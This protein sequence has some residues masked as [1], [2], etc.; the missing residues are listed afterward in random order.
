MGHEGPGHAEHAGIADQRTAAQL[1][2]LAVVARRQVGA[3]FAD[4]LFDEMVVV[5]QPF[6]GGRDRRGPRR[7][8]WRCCG[9]LRAA[10]AS[11]SARRSTSDLPEAG[12][13]EMGWLAAR[14]SACCSSRSTLKSSLRMGSSSSHRETGCARP[15][16]RR[17][18]D[19]NGS[20]LSGNARQQGLPR[21]REASRERIA[22]DRCPSTAND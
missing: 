11:L 10:R 8:P 9:R 12:V 18:S 22:T 4:L 2:K 5:E 13:V 7:R 14:L 6:R 1:G 3:D 20:G 19:F 17:S 15:K 21:D 16:A